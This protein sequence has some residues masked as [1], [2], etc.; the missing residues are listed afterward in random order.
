MSHFSK[1][2]AKREKFFHM[3]LHR[4]TEVTFGVL[5]ITED[6][7]TQ[8]FRLEAY[9]KCELLVDCVINFMANQKQN[10]TEKALYVCEILGSCSG[11]TED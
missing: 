10:M 11:V 2:W 7:M 6:S 1:P 5:D 8:G 3:R 9:K 4:N